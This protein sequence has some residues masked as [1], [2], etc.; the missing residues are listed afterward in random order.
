MAAGDPIPEMNCFVVALKDTIKREEEAERFRLSRRLGLQIVLP[1]GIALLITIIAAPVLSRSEIDVFFGDL[2]KLTSLGIVAIHTM[3]ASHDIKGS[4]VPTRIYVAISIYLLIITALLVAHAFA[5]LMVEKQSNPEALALLTAKYLFVHQVIYNH[6]AEPIIALL[7]SAYLV[8]FFFANQHI[9]KQH[10]NN[11]G[12]M[13]FT[14]AF[15][16]GANLPF[17][18]GSAVILA[19]FVVPQTSEVLG[20]HGDSFL[21]GSITFLV[22]SSMAASVC[23]DIYARPFLKV[24]GVLCRHAP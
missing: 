12:I 1:L 5:V 19:I 11:I 3:L 24:D 23:I 10:P 17:I 18:V 9:K 15:M 14:E 8:L 16:Y 22:F 13:R 21:V 6:Y 20:E 4:G 7:S 2:V